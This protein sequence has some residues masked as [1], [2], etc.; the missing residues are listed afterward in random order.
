MKI[1][2]IIS[3]NDL[4]P[5]R[6][7]RPQQRPGWTSDMNR[8]WDDV[9]ARSRGEVWDHE[10]QPTRPNIG[11]RGFSGND[12]L[13]RDGENAPGRSST[14]PDVRIPGRFNSSP[15]R[16]ANPYV[17]TQPDIGSATGG[18]WNEPNQHG[19]PLRP[20]GTPGAGMTDREYANS[21]RPQ[22]DNWL[23]QSIRTSRDPSAS[24]DRRAEAGRII[25][26]IGDEAARQG[27]A[28]DL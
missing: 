24:P 27:W 6:S 21:Q 10:D 4:A 7:Q 20:E 17:D 19:L 2:E 26:A 18:P 9:M 15:R 22:L 25:T 8:F 11:S 12:L 28:H 5:Q 16:P 3:E 14:L 23:G 1:N 13:M